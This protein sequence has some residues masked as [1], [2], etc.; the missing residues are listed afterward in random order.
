MRSVLFAALV[1]VLVATAPTPTPNPTPMGGDCGPTTVVPQG[2]P[3]SE[4][5][6]VS[7]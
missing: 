5:G 2:Q 4:Q 3:H 7:K 6:Q 1:L